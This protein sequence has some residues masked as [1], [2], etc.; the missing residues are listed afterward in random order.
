M[1]INKKVLRDTKLVCPSCKSRLVKDTLNKVYKCKNNHTYD[2]AKEGYLN[3]LMCNQ[4]K[5]KNPGDSKAMIISRKD[6]LSKGYYEALSDKIDEMI[7]QNLEKQEIDIYNIM[8]LGCGEGYY[9]TNLIN[10]M[11]GRKIEANFY[12]MD[13]SKDAVK[14]ASKVNKNNIWVVGNNFCIPIENNSLDCIISIFSPINTEECNRVLKDTGFLIRVL[15]RANHLIELRN[16]IYSQV[17]SK[18]DETFKIDSDEMNSVEE[19]NVTY[20]INLRKEDIL[21]LVKMT[22]HY[23]KT[24]PYNKEKLNL[25]ESLDV[26]IDFRIGIFKKV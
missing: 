9:L 10:Y 1:V 3:L 13:I 15:P 19:I 21:N 14:Y 6:F 4:R 26:T 7:V 2:I 18:N 5:S 11:N 20:S 16:I 17:N 12:G 25:Y 23:W 8:D 24:S 22:P